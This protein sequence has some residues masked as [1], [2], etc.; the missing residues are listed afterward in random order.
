MKGS[1]FLDLFAGSGGVAKALR[2]LGFRCLEVDIRHGYDMRDSAF[3]TK[4]VQAVSSGV[5][6]GIMA[7]PPCSSFSTARDRTGKIRSDD[8]PYGLP[9]LSPE[10]SVKVKDGNDCLNGLLRVIKAADA[11]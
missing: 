5:V 3:V 10:V 8:Y 11:R 7:A 6:S 4:L 1:Y 9:D 2:K